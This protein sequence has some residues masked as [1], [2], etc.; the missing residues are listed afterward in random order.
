METALNGKYI[1]YQHQNKAACVDAF[2]VAFPEP[3]I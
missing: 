1:S 3:N 2:I